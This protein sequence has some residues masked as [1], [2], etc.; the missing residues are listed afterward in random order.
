[1]QTIGAA[2]NYCARANDQIDRHTGSFI[3]QVAKGRGDSVIGGKRFEWSERDIF[4][5]RPGPGTSMPS[6]S[7]R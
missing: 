7:V 4:C 6:R 2:C 5:V 1:M 3:Y